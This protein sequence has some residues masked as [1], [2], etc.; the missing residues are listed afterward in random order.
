MLC[1][2]SSDPHI[3]AIRDSVEE[4]VAESA[5]GKPFHV[6]GSPVSRWIIMDYTDVL[7][8]VMDR[9]KRM[10]YALETLWND[11]PITRFDEAGHPLSAPE[12]ATSAA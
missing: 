2:G 5:G 7:V 8:H 9:E 6:E 12:R 1:T 11:A 10:L 3:K 4:G